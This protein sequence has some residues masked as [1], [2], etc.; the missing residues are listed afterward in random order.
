MALLW[1]AVATK[2]ARLLSQGL[3]SL[4][5]KLDLA[6][7]LNYVR[8]HDDI[9]LGFDDADIRACG[10][11]PRAHRRFLLDWFTGNFEGSPAR[12]RPFG[13]NTKTGDARIAGALASLVGLDTALEA[14]DQ[15]AIDHCVELILTL[16]GM[17]LS[18]GGIPLIWYGDEIGTRNDNSFLDDANKAGDTRW[19]HRPHINWD[20]AEERHNHGT[21]EQR[22]FSGLKRLIAVRKTMTA[23]ADFN[24]RELIDVDNPHLFVLLRTHP[25]LQGDSVLV[26]ANFDGTPQYLDLENLG[27]RG[28]FQF[29]QVQDLASG[30]TPALFNGRVVVP[31]YRFYWLTDQRTGLGL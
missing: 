15:E 11:E 1:D 26:V 23:F 14:N 27:N 31:P 10:Y 28:R 18:F 8:C 25:S 17:I 13:V 7:W 6:T 21:V 29:G 30:Q 22:I 5:N 2:N 19:I 20:Q 12:G 9:G 4:P 24:N 3:K 16:H